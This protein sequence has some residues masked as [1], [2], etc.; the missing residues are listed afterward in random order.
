MQQAESRRTELDGQIAERLPTWS[1][2]PTVTALQALRG[3]GTIIAVTLA[4]EVGDFAR[5]AAPRD[6]MAYLGLVPGEH[7]SGATI[8]PRG[9]TKQGNSPLRALL[10]EAA[11][12]YR[13]SAKSANG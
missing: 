11:W 1:L 10:Y 2:A 7:S 4:A 5:F 9:I 12:C 8:R 3:V 6:L 13:Q